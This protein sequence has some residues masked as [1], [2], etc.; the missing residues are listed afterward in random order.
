MLFRHTGRSII[1]WFTRLD[2]PPDVFAV[3]M[4]TGILSVAAAD[5]GYRDLDAGL[6]LVAAAAFVVLGLGFVIRAAT[7]LSRVVRPT[8]DPD[9]ALR[10]FTF[11]AACTVLA[12]HP[13]RAPVAAWLLSGL[14]VA[15]WV[16]LVP[17]A[18]ADLTSCRLAYLR[19]QA[20]GAWLLPSVATSG[21]AGTLAQLAASAR[22]PLLLVGAA[23]GVLL[24]IVTYLAVASLI[25]WRSLS[26]PLTPDR[27]PPDSWILMGALAIAALACSRIL[28][29]VQVLGAP[30][31]LGQ[32]ARILMFALWAAASVWVP[33][34]LYGQIWRS[35]HMLGTLHYERAWW[36]AV[37]PLGMYATASWA[38]G[39]GPGMARLATI[40]LVFFWVAFTAWVL[41]A[42]G[43]IHSGVARL[44]RLVGRRWPAR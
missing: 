26:Q 7:H 44:L 32:A 11:V 33:A 18:V 37:F 38:T 36:S 27:I 14:A 6:S 20:H 15:G 23:V 1:A 24:A 34:L 19:D 21:M 43:L 4:A 8:R 10:M 3:V 42:M 28:T 13:G 40:S 16:V 30:A 17:L 41:V 35:D 29:A 31:A 12:G 5:H 39:A 22:S 2:P 25:I 9:V